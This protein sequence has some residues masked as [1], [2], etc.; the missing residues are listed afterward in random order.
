MHGPSPPGNQRP[1]KKSKSVA[2]ARAPMVS[3][4]RPNSGELIE[5]ELRIEERE[6]R[7]RL[8]ISSKTKIDSTLMRLEELRFIATRA[9]VLDE[10]DAFGSRSKK[11][12]IK[13]KMKNDLG[14]EDDEDE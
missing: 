3:S 5:Q 1:A 8:S 2:T 14:D 13:N 7:E 4:G 11:N 10:V 12:L 6:A 9:T